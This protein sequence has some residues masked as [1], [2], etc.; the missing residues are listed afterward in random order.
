MTYQFDPIPDLEPLFD[1]MSRA[2]SYHLTSQRDDDFRRYAKKLHINCEA[3]HRGVGTE[4]RAILLVAPAGSGKTT[5]VNYHLAHLPYFQ[6][7]ADNFGTVASPVLR[8]KLP[9][10][11]TS[12]SAMFKILRAMKI[13]NSYARTPN[14][15]LPEIILG[16]MKA[17]NIKYLVL[18]ELQHG[19][20]GSEMGYIK[21]MQDVLKDL[22]DSDLWPLH[23][24]FIGTPDVRP[25]LKDEQVN[26]RVDVMRLLPLENQY[27]PFVGTLITKIVQEACGMT[28]EFEITDKVPARL[29]HAASKMM[30]TAI[31]LLQETC[32]D[33]FAAGRT[34]IKLEDLQE[35]YRR[36]TGCLRRD[37]IFEAKDF[38]KIKPQH[39]L[40][41]ILAGKSDEEEEVDDE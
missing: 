6:P 28:Y 26:R 8:L 29:M 20:R 7:V 11:S 22:I 41:D 2:R 38:T 15:E 32:F 4:K 31:L 16:H 27:L 34:S 10:G 19:V 9:P 40:A 21:A 13:H 5:L 33:A 14:P 18:D 12:R 39:A 23:A 36:K 1:L 37:N 30:G 24:I 25:L 35:T 17:L 3:S